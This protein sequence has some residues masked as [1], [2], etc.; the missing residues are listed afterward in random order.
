M[1][2]AKKLFYQDDIILSGIIEVDETFLANGKKWQRWGSLSTRKAPI[3][4]LI[5]RGGKVVIKCIPDRSEF[6]ME[7][8][9]RKH[10][11]E[12]SVIYTDGWLG[13]RNLQK[14]YTH[15][16]V[17]HSAREY[18][19]GEVHTNNIDNIW[20]QLKN[21]IRG[22]HHSISNKHAQDYCDEVAYKIN[23][24]HRKPFERF[25]ELLLRAVKIGSF[26]GSK[27]IPKGKIVTVPFTK[28]VSHESTSNVRTLTSCDLEEISKADNGVIDQVKVR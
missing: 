4:G 26:P 8:I 19:R 18:K 1:S 3:I 22:A 24:R 13:Y 27:S 20:K 28:Y 25:N 9:I 14:W 6:V 2:K 16:Y 7:E 5:E 23:N 10:V 11:I 17:D 21:N 15:D 12:G